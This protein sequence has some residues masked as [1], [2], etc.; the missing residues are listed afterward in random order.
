MKSE[1]EEK[2]GVAEGDKRQAAC[3]SNTQ[4]LTKHIHDASLRVQFCFNEV[5]CSRTSIKMF[6]LY[7]D[8]SFGVTS[9]GS[10]CFI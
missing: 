1:A 9:F 5:L 3:K 8:T 6:H 10:S 4:S 7:E 2:E